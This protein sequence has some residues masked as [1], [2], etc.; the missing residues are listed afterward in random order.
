M[1]LACRMSLA[2]SLY[3]P[4]AIGSGQIAFCAY[5]HSNPRPLR[6]RR[7]RRRWT[8]LPRTPN[9][10]RYNTRVY[11]LRTNKTN[12]IRTEHFCR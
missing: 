10:L 11:D 8:T 3:F 6:R 9:R 4:S 12:F 5:P 1:A 7:R 2:D